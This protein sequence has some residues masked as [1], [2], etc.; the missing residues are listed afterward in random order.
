VLAVPGQ[1]RTNDP[2]L[3]APAGGIDRWTD[4][5]VERPW[6]ASRPKKVLAGTIAVGTIDQA[7]LAIIKAKH[8]HLR[9]AGLV[10]HLLVVDE[11]HASDLYMEIILAKLLRFHQSVGGHALLL[12]ATLGS[13]ARAALLGATSPPPLKEAIA[14][15]YP[16]LT[17][18]KTNVP[19][20]LPWS[21][22][23]KRVTLE[24]S[25]EIAESERVAVR[26][27]HA[28]SLGAKVLVIR[29]TRRS[30][31]ETFEAL[32][33]L[34]PDAPTLRLSDIPTLHHGRFAREDRSRLDSAVEKAV[35]KVRPEG[36]HIVIGTQTL[37][38]SLDIDA[39]LIITDLC[40]ADVLLQRIG[41]L[42]RHQ[43]SRPAGFETPRAIV[44]SPA[45][46][47]P[48][49]RRP[50][51]GLGATDRYTQ[52]YPDLVGLEA[53]RRLILTE[54]VWTI[55]AMN[56]RLVELTTHPEEITRLCDEL[57]ARDPDWAQ[58][59]NRRFGR[60]FVQRSEAARAI[61]RTDK[62]FDDPEA[63]FGI[64]CDAA[65]RL[66]ARDLLIEL[67]E[68]AR[69]PFGGQVKT[70]AVP[71]HWWSGRIEETNDMT[72]EGTVEDDGSL[73]IKVQQALFHYS[74]IGL[75]PLV[76]SRHSK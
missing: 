60:T 57:V 36:G 3:Q 65:T 24:S 58:A 70:F 33:R 49:I 1:G 61:L 5:R 38:Q 21:G 25:T 32:M 8:A 45:D 6:A 11:V 63:Y 15:P 43:R 44:F 48:L 12:S 27:A 51:H 30:A 29:N 53:T 56:R 64:D 76:E 23:E 7:L 17:N 47:T 35:G 42:H 73:L 22:W 14:Q 40:P 26:A 37:E 66:G 72:A 34:Y 59:T 50:A 67:T 41:R 75:R 10:R 13:R 28:S 71:F 54:P 68:P 2:G 16:A 19:R 74:A 18:D 55:P 69:G 39:D 20:A 9:L 4:E 52:P 46:L 31:V 62:G